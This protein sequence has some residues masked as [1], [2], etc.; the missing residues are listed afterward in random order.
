MCAGLWLRVDDIRVS[1][2]CPSFW[3]QTP[4]LLFRA[5]SQSYSPTLFPG[6]WE[7]MGGADRQPGLL[8]TILGLD[9]G[10]L[11]SSPAFLLAAGLGQT[12]KLS[13][14]QFLP[15]KRKEDA[16]WTEVP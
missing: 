13:E 7:P 15:L 5:I 4:W 16:G 10:P 14:P 12:L 1:E 11:G 8:G 3:E 6:I 2:N 9:P